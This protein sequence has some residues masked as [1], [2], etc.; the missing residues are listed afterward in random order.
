MIYVT[1]QILSKINN[2]NFSQS[3]DI[4]KIFKLEGIVFKMQIE[5]NSNITFIVKLRLDLK[6]GGAVYFLNLSLFASS[7]LAVRADKEHRNPF[8][9]ITGDYTGGIHAGCYRSLKNFRWHIFAADYFFSLV[10]GCTQLS[11]T[12]WLKTLH[13]LILS[14]RKSSNWI[15]SSGTRFHAVGVHVG[16]RSLFHFTNDNNDN[17]TSIMTM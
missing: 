2:F 6:K 12:R 9:R 4:V 15:A 14:S 5:M 17:K 3:V 7:P 13:I 1:K 10:R 16:G 8:N 11:M